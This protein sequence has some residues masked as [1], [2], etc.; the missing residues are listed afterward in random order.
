MCSKVLV[1]LMVIITSMLTVQ[2]HWCFIHHT[3]LFALKDWLKVELD[4]METIGVIKK[5]TKLTKWVSSVVITET[6]NGKISV[7]LDPRDLNKEIM[8]EYYPM[9]IVEEV[10]AQLN[11]ATV[12]SML[13]ASSGF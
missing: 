11:G 5:I 3:K 6:K 12:F 10:T 4:Q 13:Q 1:A 9:K 7:C 2:F 8:R